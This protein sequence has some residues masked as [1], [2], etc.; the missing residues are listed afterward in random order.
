DDGL[1]KAV[2][3][4]HELRQVA[5]NG[6]RA[7][8]QSNDSLEILGL[9]LAIRNLIAEAVF[10]SLAGPPACCVNV[11][12][13]AMHSVWSEKSVFNSLPQAVGVNG[14]AKVGISVPV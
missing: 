3:I 5:G 1:G 2:S 11:C 10:L 14:I 6:L 13:D 4:P 12:D 9:I 8:P 7:C